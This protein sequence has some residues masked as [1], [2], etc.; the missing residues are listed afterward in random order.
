MSRRK[1][2][3]DAGIAALKPRAARYS[4]PDPELGGHYVRVTPS[5]AKSYCAVARDP[6]AGKQVWATISPTDLMNIEDARDKARNAI[7]RIKAGLAPFEEMPTK[8]DTYRDVAEN[9][10]KRYVVPKGLRSRY[11]IERC[12]NVYVFPKWE[13]LDFLTIRRADIARLLDSVQDNHGPR[14]ADMVLAITR[15][16]A[17]WFAS[18]HDDYVSPFTRGMRRSERGSG[19]RARI[20]DDEELRAIWRAAETSGTFGAILRFA[21]LTA[22]RE[23]KI[24]TI[25]WADVNA[26]EWLIATVEREKGTGGALVLP[27]AALAIISSRDRF[28]KNPYVFAGRGPG[29][30]KGFSP[31]KRAFDKRLPGIAPWVIHDLRRT[32]RSLMARAGVRPEIAERVMGHAIDG[33]EGVYDRHQYRDEKKDA[34]GRLDALIR[35]ILVPSDNVVPMRRADP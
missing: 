31:C 35:A 16:I 2:L 17:N 7:R 33:V 25:K 27:E 8:P 10:I 6:V 23:A 22:Q 29:H 28:K 13:K 12:L 20:L 3:S 24:A 18:R 4:F 34:L 14:Q 32:A 19:K 5:G 9:Y 15:G 1:S 26:G 21:L 30:F 11:E